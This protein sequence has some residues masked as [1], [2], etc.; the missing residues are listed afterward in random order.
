MTAP[1]ASISNSRSGYA[2][3]SRSFF[4]HC[5]APITQAV[6]SCPV[7]HHTERYL[8][9][10][11]RGFRANRFDRGLFQ[12]SWGY[13]SAGEAHRI[14]ET[15]GHLLQTDTLL[16]GDY[17]LPN[18]ILDNWRFSGF[19]DLGN[20]GAGDRHIDIFWAMWTFVFNLKT[21]KYSERFIDAYGR[22]NVD[23]ERLRIVAAAEMF[24]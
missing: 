18:I 19:I 4:G 8:A 13:T 23:E 17:C 9:N 14:I 15:R 1:Q 21:D 11:E 6:L 16:H 20:G 2:T 24:G 3:R 7:P 10:A 5:T 12:N 22:A